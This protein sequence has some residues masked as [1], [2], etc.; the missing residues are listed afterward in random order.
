LAHTIP[1]AAG[2]LLVATVVTVPGSIVIAGMMVP[3]SGA[4][5]PGRIEL[6]DSVHGAIDAITQGT[7]QGLEVFLNLIATLLVFVALIHLCNSLLG[8]L[9]DVGGESLSLQRMMGWLF[10]PVAWLI[11]VPWGEAHTFGALLGT[12]T[13]LNEL[14]AFQDLTALPPGSLGDRSRLLA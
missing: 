7:R 13:A 14:L 8:L 3:E 4:L 2:H 1:D 12:K 10:A 11:G 9:P 5:T 6:Q